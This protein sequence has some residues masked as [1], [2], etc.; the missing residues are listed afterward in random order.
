MPEPGIEPGY[1]PCKGD[2]RTTQL[3]RR[4]VKAGI[5]PAFSSSRDDAAPFS[6][7]TLVDPTR[8]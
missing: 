5:E 2:A 4:I 1:S 7:M 6:Y 3:F 8:T